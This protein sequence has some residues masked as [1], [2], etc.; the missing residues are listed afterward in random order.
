MSKEIEKSIDAERW[1]EARQKIRLALRKEPDDHW[2]LTRLGLTYY[3]E[4]N[5]SR[6][7]FYATKAMKIAPACPLV[8]WDYAGT[9]SM[10]D[11]NKEA[12]AIYQKL[13]KRGEKRIA[14]GRCGEGLS[15]A[16]GL[17]A[18]CL[19]RIGICYEDNGQTKRACHYYQQHLARRGPGCRSIYSAIEVKKRFIKCK[20]R[21]N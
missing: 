9:L 18:D 19:Y 15:W 12:I 8:L 4:R 7:L 6:A 13:V 20:K 17:V 14:Y 10:L 11:R 16:R 2:L 3:E 21:T 1:K 5:Y